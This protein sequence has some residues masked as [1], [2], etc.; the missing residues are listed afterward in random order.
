M[1]CQASTLVAAAP[2]A[3]LQQVVA[4]AAVLRTH[5][6]HDFVHFARAQAGVPH[7]NLL[8]EGDRARR[9]ARV[10]GKYAYEAREN[11]RCEDKAVGQH[12]GTLVQ[13]WQHVAG[14]RCS[15]TCHQLSS[16]SG[17]QWPTWCIIFMTS[18]CIFH[19][20]DLNTTVEHT[21]TTPIGPIILQWAVAA[22][23]G[24]MK[25]QIPEP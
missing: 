13:Q 22:V 17:D 3:H 14:S 23:A 16:S 20:I 5:G 7:R 2:T 6:L 19:A 1:L 25:F 21:H 12:N 9:L 15:A 11:R 8:A 4:V 10:G 18:E 24:N